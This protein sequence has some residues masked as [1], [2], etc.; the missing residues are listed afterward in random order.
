[1]IRSNTPSPTCHRAYSKQISFNPKFLLTHSSIAPIH[2]PLP[3]LSSHSSDLRWLPIRPSHPRS[4]T[5]FSPPFV[6]PP[7]YKNPTCNDL[8]KSGSI[9]LQM[10]SIRFWIRR[11]I[12]LP[13]P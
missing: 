3:S 10:L 1:M 4:G 11:S 5:D 2:P 13:P 7:A 9:P 12:H 6:R 8:R